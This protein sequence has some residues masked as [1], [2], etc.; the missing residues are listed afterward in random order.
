MKITCKKQDDLPEGTVLV[1]S[2]AE[3]FV[4]EILLTRVIKALQKTIGK[5]TGKTIIAK[6]PNMRV[7]IVPTMM[8]DPQH[9]EILFPKSFRDKEMQP[10]LLML[11]K[12]LKEFKKNRL[13]ILAKHVSPVERV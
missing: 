11:L 2:N 7:S 9:V 4:N 5:T 13:R 10:P 1:K 12:D 8:R 6:I 3:N